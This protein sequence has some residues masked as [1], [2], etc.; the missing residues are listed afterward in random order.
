MRLALTFRSPT[1]SRQCLVSA[2]PST[3]VGGLFP[4]WDAPVF[5]GSQLLDHAAPLADSG[6]RQ[7]SILDLGSQRDLPAVPQPGQLCLL[8]IGGPATGSWAPL[9]VGVT[10]VGRDAPIRLDDP[11]ISRIHFRLRI[12]QDGW[13]TVEDCGSKN[14]IRVDGVV[15]TGPRRLE[16][17]EIITAG[18]SQLTVLAAPMADAALTPAGDGCLEF[19]RPPRIRPP[20]GVPTVVLPSVPTAPTHAPVQI[21]AM[22]T[23]LLA[24]GAMAVIS[25]QV[26]FLAIAVLTPLMGVGTLMTDRRRGRKSHRHQM[27]QYRER[28]AQ[29]RAAIAQAVRDER[30]RLRDAHPDPGTALLRAGMPSSRLWERRAEDDDFLTVRIGTGT[31]PPSLNVSGGA[32]EEQPEVSLLTETPVTL[33]LRSSH[34]L[35]VAGD[36]TAIRD[37]GRAILTTLVATHSPRDLVITVLTGPDGDRAWEWVRWLPHCRPDRA[38]L[39]LCRLGNNPST[40]AARV[41]ELTELLAQR[42]SQAGEHR[43]EIQP[44]HLVVLDGS[45]QLR[46]DHAISPLI[47]SGGELGIH[48]LCLDNLATQ[49]PESCKAIVDLRPDR[50]GTGASLRRTG[51]PPIDGI[52]PDRLSPAAAETLARALSPLR[53]SGALQIGGRLPASVRLL[54]M[55]NLDPPQ[56]AAIQALWRRG[57]TTAIPIGRDSDR[58]FVLDL[59]QG[60][61]ML[62]GGTTGAGKSELLQTIVAS[63][64][65]HNRPDHMVFVLIDYKG[66]AA[67]RG[68]VDLPHT[69]GMVTDLDTASVERA[70]VSLRAEL[71]RRKAVLDAADKPDILRYWD[72]IGDRRDADPLPRLVLVV[73]EF[74]VMADAMPEQLKALV[75]IAA[76]GRSLGVH[77]ILATQRPAGAVT[78]DMRANVNLSIALRVATDQDSLDV[79]GVADAARLSPEHP[80]R[81]YLQVG[82][83]RPLAFQAARVGGLRPGLRPRE[84]HVVVQEVPWHDL[85]R[86]LPVPDAAPPAP[87]DP[88]DL[89][90]LVEAIRAAA[91]ASGVSAP[92]PPWRPP[93]PTDLPL[94]EVGPSTPLRLAYG[95]IDLPGE[96][97]QVPALYDLV[98]QGHLLVAGAPRSGRSTVLRALAAAAT[99]TPLADLHVY[100]LDCGG[101]GLASLGLLPQCGAVVTPADPD[102]VDRLLGRLSR[103]LVS[104]LQQLEAAGC[105]DLAE[106]RASGAAEIPPYILF[107]IDRYDAFVSQFEGADGGRLVGQV[108]QL[109]QNSLS[110]GFRLVL[111]GDRSLVSGRIGGMVEAKLMLR[112]ADRTDYAVVGL[113]PRSLPAE[114]PTGRAFLLPGGAAVQIAHAGLSAEGASQSA[115]IRE[116]AQR[117]ARSGE[118]VPFRVDALPFSITMVEALRLPHQGDGVLIGVGGDEL[119]QV[120][121]DSPVVLVLGANGSG[122]STALATLAASLAGSGDRQLILITPRRSRL[123]ELLGGLEGVSAFGPEDLDSPALTEALGAIGPRSVIVVDDSELLAEHPLATRLVTVLRAIRDG[124]ATF[125]AAASVDEAAGNFRGIVPELRKFKCGL[126]IA[127]TQVTQGDTLGTRL[128]RS[129]VGTTVP[130]RGV[131]VNQGSAITVQVPVA[132]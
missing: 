55:L 62:V 2:D 86:P 41:G 22:L 35:G 93:L 32:D 40:I 27:E 16:A 130:M 102:R 25:H 18:S 122:R 96:Q 36:R 128:Q 126:L 94:A 125:L 52:R 129:M 105:S 89:S 116:L 107:L 123:P 72:A 127:P 74:K 99:G 132:Q 85:G 21:F 71:Q 59:A 76:Q 19:S 91:P 112:M 30:T 57:R 47:D 90:V 84:A 7:G 9:S 120:R 110:A 17:G 95:R 117:S 33:S 63:L 42:S 34:A 29:A 68:C 11:T 92:A 13:V 44:A 61:H 104:R 8:V 108:Q 109:L 24:A 31:L 60:P 3:A 54:E 23:P 51:E 100:A 77:L 64:A 45:Y 111:T 38:D 43:A 119:S 56:P 82:T 20:Q 48:F 80:G 114:I 88:T 69:V 28:L 6:V 70:L 75:D 98:R 1:G 78:G 53:D 83:A 26:A 49:L 106:L 101:G 121:V 58:P 65:A 118:R 12:G 14:G 97:R 81:A 131:V 4:D 66:G 73:D 37:L 5:M 10:K 46:Q 79:I 67:F 115:A 50:Q 15:L 103:E 39:A 87:D 124:G 113:S